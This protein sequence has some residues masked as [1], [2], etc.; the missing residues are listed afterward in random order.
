M[1]EHAG[2]LLSFKI[3]ILLES[4]KKDRKRNVKASMQS[5]I[6]FSTLDKIGFSTA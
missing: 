4:K 6:I 5:G 3:Q 1:P 2:V